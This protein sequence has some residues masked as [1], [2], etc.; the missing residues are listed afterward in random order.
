MTIELNN[1]TKLQLNG[2]SNVVIGGSYENYD[3]ER[4]KEVDE[5]TVNYFDGT[6]WIDITELIYELDAL[7]PIKQHGSLVAALENKIAW[8]T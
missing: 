4:I 3:F 2:N 7:L 1:N 6:N 8:N 5:L